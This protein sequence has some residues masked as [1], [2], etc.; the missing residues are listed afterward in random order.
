MALVFFLK[1]LPRCC[2]IQGYAGQLTVDPVTIEN[3]LV[4]MRRA[5]LMI[6]RLNAYFDREGLVAT[7]VL[8]SNHH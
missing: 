2:V 6:R 8:L 4:M 1:E 7:P 3:A 5:S